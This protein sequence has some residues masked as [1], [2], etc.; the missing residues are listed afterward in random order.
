M[1]LETNPV[2]K[3][4]WFFWQPLSNALALYALRDDYN[5]GAVVF[6][7]AALLMAVLIWGGYRTVA[8]QTATSVKKKWLFCALG[9]PVLA[10]AISLAAAERAI[11]YRTLFALSGLMLVL[12]VYALRSLRLTQRIKLPVYYACLVLII[13]L[14]GVTANRNTFTLFAEPQGYEWEMVY[15][16]VMRTNFKAATKVYLITPNLVD[17]STERMFTD[18]FGSLSSDSGWTPKEMFKAAIRDRFGSKMPKGT[19]YTFT[20]GRE[21]PA[22]RAYDLVID[23]RKLKNLRTP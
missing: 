10:H 2:T 7:S 4:A 5:T 21:E 19:S 14:A 1:A 12:V 23:M 3:L 17:R 8:G 11:G 16:A 13:V 18:E 6:W 15:N 9:L 20:S 22:P